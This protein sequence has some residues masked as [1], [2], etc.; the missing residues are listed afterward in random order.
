M[1]VVI[2]PA[3]RFEQLASAGENDVGP[4]Q[5]QALT[6]YQP[7]W[8]EGPMQVKPSTSELADAGYQMEAE[9]IYVYELP[10]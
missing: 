8:V 5:E 6:P 10:E 2:E 1:A 3:L 4:R 7:Y 9:K